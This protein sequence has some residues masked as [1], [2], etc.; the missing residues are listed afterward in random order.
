MQSLKK[1]K[2]QKRMFKRPEMIKQDL[3]GMSSEKKQ[4]L[5]ELKWQKKSSKELEWQAAVFKKH[6]MAKKNFKIAHIKT[7]NL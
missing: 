1:L 6:E 3:S 7:R 4:A 5:E 2:W